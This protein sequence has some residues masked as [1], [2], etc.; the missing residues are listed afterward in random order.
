LHDA[1]FGPSFLGAKVAIFFGRI[2][3]L[4]YS[5]ADFH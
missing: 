2:D 1:F 4:L 5:V 3:N